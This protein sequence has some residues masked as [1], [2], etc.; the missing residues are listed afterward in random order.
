MADD[1]KGAALIAASNIAIFDKDDD[2]VKRINKTAFVASRLV[3][4]LNAI[5]KRREA[6]TVKKSKA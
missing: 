6:T 5:E 1:M 2:Q 4:V 3:A